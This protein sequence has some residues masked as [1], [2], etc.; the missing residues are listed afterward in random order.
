[1]GLEGILLKTSICEFK[2]VLTFTIKLKKVEIDR[3][4]NSHSSHGLFIKTDTKTIKI[5]FFCAR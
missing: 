2:T 3:Q 4:V 5:Y 1:M